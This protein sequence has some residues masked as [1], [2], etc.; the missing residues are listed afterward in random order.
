MGGLRKYMPITYSTV[1]I[2]ALALR[3]HPAVRRL[4]LQGRDHR[5]GAP[6][7]DSRARLRLLRRAGRRV[8]HRVLLVPD[9]VPGVPRQGALRHRR[10]ITTRTR[11]P[12]H[13][14]DASA[15]PATSPIAW[16][17]TAAR[18]TESPWVVTVPLI[19]LAIPSVL[20]RLGVHRADAVRRL[21]RQRDRRRC[22]EHDV[23]AELE[24]EWHGVGAFIAARPAERAVLARARRH[25][26]G[27]VLL[28]RQPG[29]AGAHR[30]RLPAR[31]TRC[32]TTS[33]TST[34]STTGSSPAA[35]ARVGQLA[36]R[37]SA[38]ARSSTASSSTAPRASSAGAPRCCARCRPGYIYHYAFTMII[39]VFALL[40]W[41]AVR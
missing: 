7:D 1:V 30:E 36:C 26:R 39:G 20:R 18:R 12:T 41:W 40:T 33:T 2:G 5:G 22:R 15:T 23:L 24:A 9:G 11:T 35:R 25:R 29:A 6:V 34:S 38:T 3:R 4:L 8:R 27:L 32:S 28:P 21:L 37:T 31:S 19:L 17:R 14:H 10:T 16:T 13:A